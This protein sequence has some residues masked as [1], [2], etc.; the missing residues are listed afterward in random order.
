MK[1]KDKAKEL[2]EKF[3]KAEDEHG[4]HSINSFRARQCALICVNNIIAANPHSNPFNTS[5]YST[6]DYWLEVKKEIMELK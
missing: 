5:V 2:I 1:A 6:M 4:F 3:Y